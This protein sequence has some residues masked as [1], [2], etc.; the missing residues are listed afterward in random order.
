MLEAEINCPADG[1]RKKVR[2]RKQCG[3]QDLGQNVQSSEIRRVA[4]QGQLNEVLNRTAPKLCPDPLV[5][6]LRM[7]DE[8]WDDVL[9]TAAREVRD[10]AAQTATRV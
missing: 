10:V 9:A 5:L 3:W 7:P 8:P 4:N 2:I 1:Q 6:A